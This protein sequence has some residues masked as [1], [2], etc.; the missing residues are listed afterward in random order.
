MFRRSFFDVISRSRRSG[1]SSSFRK[2][3]TFRPTFEPLEQRM[4]LSITMAQ[5]STQ[6]IVYTTTNTSSNWY[7]DSR[8]LQV[9]FTPP[10]GSGLSPIVVK[11]F[12]DGGSTFNVRFTPTTTGTWTYSTTGS[13]ITG[14][15]NT[16]EALGSQIVVSAAVSGNHGFVRI[17]PTYTNSFVYDD[18]TR[19]FMMGQTYYDWLDGAMA[20]DNWKTSVD[21][22]QAY[23]FTKV[24]FDVYANN[25]PTEHND[26][27]D[28]IPYAG[29]PASPDRDH[30]DL[31]TLSFD[32][33]TYFQKMDEMIQYMSSK[34]LVADL[35]VTTP[36]G[37]VSQNNIQFGTDTQNDRFVTYVVNRYAAYDNVIWCMGNEWEKSGWASNYPQDKADYNRLSNLVRNQDPWM[38]QGSAL[39]PLTIHGLQVW[40][41]PQG[42]FQFFDQSWPTYA[43]MQYGPQSGYQ[44]VGDNLAIR[45]N[46]GHDMPVVNDEFKYIGQLSRV[47]HRNA[48]WGIAT[49][50]GYSSTADIQ[51]NPNGMGVSEST[52]DWTVPPGGEY[53][54]VQQLNSFF[55]T[56]G[57][58]Y[59]KMASH[60]ELKSGSSRDYLLAEPGRQYVLYTAAGD[61]SA[62]INLSGYG[63]DFAVVKFDPTNG[64]MTDLG[65]VAGGAI[66]TWNLTGTNS[67][68]GTDWVLLVT[69]LDI[70]GVG[71]AAPSDLVATVVSTSRIDLNWTDNSSVETGFEID[72]A[73]D[74]SFTGDLTTFTVGANITTYESTGLTNGATYYY[75]VRAT[76][77]GSNDSANSNTASAMAG[78]LPPVAPRDLAVRSSQHRR[79]T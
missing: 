18:G 51:E 75:R 39:R 47:D 43:T 66:H 57:I 4:L 9:T 10:S 14:L 33:L 31:T 44:D 11:G 73:A 46:L 6:D 63:G 2:I 23:G 60:N 78:N 38:T 53:T 65:T 42:L 58:E 71:P 5:W 45:N 19:Y 12:W 25:V 24:R 56:K 55:T 20:N 30:L 28:K 50:G 52:G 21:S 68:G 36:Y 26:Y 74:S 77:G 22:M 72:R 48:L 69:R 64:T 35:I 34:G 16:T 40:S 70:I 54:D 59:W 67:A 15:T 3:K 8:Q 76:I 7:T 1:H 41:D 17:D 27:P 29:T 62:G 79:S 49:A 13:T 61:S 37:V 32:G